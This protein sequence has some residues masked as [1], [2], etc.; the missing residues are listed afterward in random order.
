MGLEI[1][2]F[3]SAHGSHTKNARRESLGGANRYEHIHTRARANTYTHKYIYVYMYVY[4]YMI[5]WHEGNI[6]Q[7]AIESQ[8]HG[9]NGDFYYEYPFV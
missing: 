7:R 3:N 5:S 8:K 2:D 9:T 6:F 4:I 1:S